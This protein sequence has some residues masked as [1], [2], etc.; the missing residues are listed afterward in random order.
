MIVNSLVSRGL[1]YC[2]S[3]PFTVDD[4]HKNKLQRIEIHLSAEDLIIVILFLLTSMIN[5]KKLQRIKIT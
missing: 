1:D 2:N 4:K 3:L 5:I